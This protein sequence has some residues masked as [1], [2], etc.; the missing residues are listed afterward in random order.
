MALRITRRPKAK[1][2]RAAAAEP[3]TETVPAA[4]PVT[5]TAPPPAPEPP[6]REHL[7]GSV[8][9]VRQSFEET[10]AQRGYTGEM[11]QYRRS[12]AADVGDAD[13]RAAVL[14][15]AGHTG[16]VIWPEG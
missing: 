14:R 3:V 12:L 16:E 4:G 9:R 11:A 8:Y 1:S 7:Y 6:R 13:H 15:R 10:M 2:K 5:G